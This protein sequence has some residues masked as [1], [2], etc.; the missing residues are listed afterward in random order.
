[1]NKDDFITSTVNDS[2]HL[3]GSGM[4]KTLLPKTEV[5]AMAAISK[6]MS[7]IILFDHPV[8]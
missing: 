8:G 2:S 6:A 4:G 7:L 5:W 3:K 1:M